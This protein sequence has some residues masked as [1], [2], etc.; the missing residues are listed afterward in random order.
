MFLN[1]MSRVT[2]YKPHN[3]DC[4][5]GLEVVYYLLGVCNYN[6]S[7][8]NWRDMQYKQNDFKIQR[9]ILE[10]IF[11]IQKNTN[12]TLLGGEPTLCTYFTKLLKFIENNKPVTMQIEVQTHGEFKQELIKVLEECELKVSVSI[13]Y[14]YIKNISKLIGNIMALESIGKLNRIDFMFEDTNIKK[15][16]TLF[17]MLEMAGL[18]EKITPTY[19]YYKLPISRNRQTVNKTLYNNF[20]ECI[21]KCGDRELYDISLNDGEVCTLDASELYEQELDFSGWK[22]KAGAELMI[23]DNKGNYSQCTSSFFYDKVK[24]NLLDASEI[25]LD[26]ISGEGCV[27][28]YNKC[29]W[30][31]Y[32]KRD[33]L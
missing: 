10:I 23:I 12:I 31:L 19:G 28:N 16:K 1:V 18:L 20:K 9:D 25:F 2:Y 29:N 7:Y 24:A 21:D 4:H 30:D 6:C 32:T 26:T 15:Q 27:C 3:L 5:G 14:N 17:R 22:C 11:K 33:L 13:H 8:C